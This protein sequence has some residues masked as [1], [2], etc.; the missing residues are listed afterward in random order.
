MRCAPP[1]PDIQPYFKLH[2]STNWETQDAEPLLVIGTHKE[3][4]IK[5]HPVLKARL[6]KSGGRQP[7]RAWNLIWAITKARPG[8][9]ARQEKGRAEP[10]REYHFLELDR[11]Q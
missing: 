8:I 10:S 6:N 1:D 4:M 9:V 11:G 2:G 5:R 7:G 3:A